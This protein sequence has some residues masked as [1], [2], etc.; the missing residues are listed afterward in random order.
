[1]HRIPV[2]K[3]KTDG[4]TS[5]SLSGAKDT[6]TNVHFSCQKDF[7][8]ERPQLNLGYV[9]CLQGRACTFTKVA[10]GTRD[11]LKLGR[12]KGMAHSGLLTMDSIAALTAAAGRAIIIMYV[13][14]DLCFLFMCIIVQVI[15][16]CST[17]DIKE[18]S[19]IQ[20]NVPQARLEKTPM[21]P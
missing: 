14:S 7:L 6:E 10:T 19:G 9:I 20:G 17:I 11:N 13:L 16:S 2:T 5:K 8:S 1:M 18:T 12:E 21:S 3:I 15:L 4:I